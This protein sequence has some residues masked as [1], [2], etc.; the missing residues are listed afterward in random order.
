MVVGMLNE[1]S[2]WKGILDT[3]RR[4]C[5]YKAQLDVTFFIDEMF[6]QGNFILMDML[7]EECP[8][9]ELSTTLLVSIL[10]STYAAHSMLRKR[11]EFY[12]RVKEKFEKQYDEKELQDLLR[13]LE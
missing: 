12:K 6:H 10:S 5:P 13:G 8:I 1:R 4:N 2:K 7:L 3:D 9:E 11:Q